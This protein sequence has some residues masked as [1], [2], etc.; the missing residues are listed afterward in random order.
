MRPSSATFLRNGHNYVNL[1]RI[2]PLSPARYTRTMR[3]LLFALPSLAAAT[4]VYAGMRALCPGIPDS[5][6]AIVAGTL[7]IGSMLALDRAFGR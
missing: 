6:A 7:F 3:F 1:E 2:D 5:L 4:F